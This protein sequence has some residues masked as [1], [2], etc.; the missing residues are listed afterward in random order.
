MAVKIGSA[1]HDENGKYS[2][3]KKGDQ[4]GSEV[5]TQDWYKS[6]KGWVVIR[7]K[8]DEVRKKIAEAMQA[9]CDNKHVGYSQSDRYSLFNAAKLVGYDI[10]KVVSDVNT[11]CSACVRVCCC[12]AGVI[13][14]DFNT[15]NEASI[16][17]DTGKFDILTD[18]KYT[19]SS[20]YLLAGDILVT[21]TK[22][23]TVVVLNNGAKIKVEKPKPVKKKTTIPKPAVAPLNFGSNGDNVK[24]LQKDLNYVL[25]TPFNRLAEDGLY[26]KKTKAAVIEFQNEYNAGKAEAGNYGILT[27]KKM[28]K[29]LTKPNVPTGKI[30]RLD[31]GKKVRLL[32]LC[33]NYL[34]DS[35][36][37]VT[38]IADNKTI[39]ALKEIQKA[40]NITKELG[41]YGTTTQ[42]L[43]KKLMK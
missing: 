8:D 21:K 9:A 43:F 19:N 28:I 6:S 38:G 13:V 33:L 32:Q 2:G 40:N 36:L 20:D 37:K 15:S 31:I 5:S 7:A 17:K 22:G 39:K 34:I 18:T 24:Q 3:G 23:H 30:Q 14:G 27:E 4:T 12:Y 25:A 41:I 35:N 26:G 29:L 10:S 42:E 16:L 1:R 11:D